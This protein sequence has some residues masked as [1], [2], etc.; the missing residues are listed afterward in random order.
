MDEIGFDESDREKI[1][2]L[3]CAILELGNI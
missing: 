1:W 2:S 3:V